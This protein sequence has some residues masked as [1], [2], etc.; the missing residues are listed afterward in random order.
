M[1]FRVRRLGF[2]VWV[3]GLGLGV[4]GSFGFK[5]HITKTKKKNH[6]M[7]NEGWGHGVCFFT[8]LW[9]QT[10]DPQTKDLRSSCRW[11]SCSADVVA[12]AQC[13]NHLEL[14]PDVSGI[15]PI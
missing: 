7:E 13:I 9:S 15:K 10:L 3:W 14:S 2:E 4:T 12:Q 6:H 11:T 5:A 8:T 1:G